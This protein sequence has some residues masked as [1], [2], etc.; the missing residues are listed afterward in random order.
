MAQV[1]TKEI[2]CAPYTAKNFIY[3]SLTTGEVLDNEPDSESWDLVF[4][5]YHDESIPYIV[6]G[7]LTNVN[8]GNS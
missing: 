4:T 2:T 6:T 5:K 1:E 3:F 7:V 8:S